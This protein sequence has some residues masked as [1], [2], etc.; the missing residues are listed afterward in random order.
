[1]QFAFRALKT[2]AAIGGSSDPLMI[3]MQAPCGAGQVWTFA[4]EVC[5]LA[6]LLQSIL[7]K[8]AS[9]AF[10]SYRDIAISLTL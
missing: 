4:V 3:A 2:V 6:H 5:Y 1:M 8:P 10:L 9:K 7:S